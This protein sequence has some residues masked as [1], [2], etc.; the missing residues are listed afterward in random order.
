MVIFKAIKKTF[1]NLNKVI[2]LFIFFQVLNEL[3]NFA[4]NFQTI[5]I[6]LRHKN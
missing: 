3:S 1:Q 2:S 6:I 5:E 4:F